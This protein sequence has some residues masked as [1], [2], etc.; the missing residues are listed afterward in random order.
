MSLLFIENINDSVGSDS[1]GR[2]LF[3]AILAHAIYG[4]VAV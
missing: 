1:F 3:T 2:E 4:S